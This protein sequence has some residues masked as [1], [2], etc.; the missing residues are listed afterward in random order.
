MTIT[1]QE[2]AQAEKRAQAQRRAGYAISARYARLTVRAVVQLSTGVQTSVP[3][4]LIEELAGASPSAL[5]VI[6][7]TPSGLGLHWP[8]L[9]T[10]LYVPDLLVGQLGSKRWM[11]AQLDAVGG[12]V[13]SAANIISSRE[14]G[15][16]GGLPR[17]AIG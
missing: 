10:D 16:K 5:S 13:R 17:K 7:I 4:G 9:D 1:E 14:N 2:F 8:M 3:S 6:E 11:A 12:S 15:R